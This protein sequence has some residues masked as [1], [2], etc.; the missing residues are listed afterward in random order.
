MTINYTTL[1]G[2]AQPVTGT[3]QGTWGDTV[4]TEITALLEDAIAD[5]ATFSVT[6][7]DVTLTSTAGQANQARMAILLVTGTPGVSRNIIAPSQSKW[8]IVKNSS[9]ASVV[10]KGSATTGVTILAGTEALCFW[11]GSDFE[12]VGVNGPSSS[13]DNAVVRF[14]GTTGKVIQN[15]GVTID[16]SNN[17]SG[18]A[19]LN[20][21]TADLTNIEVT[22]IKAKDGT[23]SASIADSTG[24]FTHATA[25]VFPAGTVS[26]PSITTTGDTNTGIFF[27]A[28]DTIAFTEGGA[29]AMRINSSGQLVIGTT[30]TPSQTYEVLQ[31]VNSGGAGLGLGRT[32]ASTISA[33]A[34]LGGI[35]FLGAGLATSG[36]IW[37][38]T[39]AAQGSNDLPS[40]ITFGTAADGSGSVTERMRIDSSGNVGIGTSSPASGVRLHVDASGG[41]VIRVTRLSSSA[42]A[43]GQ[44]EN[45]GTNTTLTSSG[46]TVFNTNGSSER[47]RIDSSGN[48]LV[49]ATATPY[50]SRFAI[51]GAKDATAG[52]P[53]NQLQVFDTT[54]QTTNVGGAI[55]FGGYYDSTNYTGWASIA[56]NKENSTS[57][58]YA[59]YLGFYT[60]PNGGSNTERA[61]IDSSGNFGIGTTSPSSYGTL[62]IVQAG[63]ASAIGY[64]CT[65]ASYTSETFFLGAD[66]NT[67]N[68]TFYYIAAYNY[69][70]TAYKFRVADSGTVTNTTGTYTTISDLKLKQDITDASSQWNDIKALRIVNYRLKEYVQND[71]DSKPF[72]GLIAQ[73]VEQV[74]PGLVEEQEDVIP[75]E[76]GKLI[77]NGEVT[78]GV[79]TSI[80]YMKAVKALQEAMERIETLEA[81]NAAFEA[82]LAALE[83]K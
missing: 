68:N 25:T 48:V 26:L 52:L 11:N 54:A 66:R 80:L 1:L 61:R 39:D 51:F 28:A 21:T 55:S 83:N 30:T 20:A 16:D 2:L 60:R 22:N 50:S 64:R 41:G 13:T 81:Q 75:D 49:G 12:I 65:N 6:S 5:A 32:S 73:E 3:E 45:D 38:Y 58:N 53:M 72:L 27:P 79:K 78:K 59:G 34:F 62:G 37:C 56:G 18:V 76:D 10:L 15:S 57:G 71:P 70:A 9:D 19:Q 63:N 43:Y 46:A 77:K 33:D 42:T 23:A 40:R 4:N 8:Y 17:V 69:G 67:T 36:Y 31:G 14:D 47:M 29:E 74:C 24:I 82:R 44:L 7:G 35:D